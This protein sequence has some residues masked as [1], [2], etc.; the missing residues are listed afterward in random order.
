MLF[1]NP[2]YL[3]AFLGLLLPLAIHLWNRKQGKTIYVGSIRWL[4]ASENRRFNSLRLHEI[5]LWILRSLLIILLVLLLVDLSWENKTALSKFKTWILIEPNLLKDTKIREQVKDL[6]SKEDELHLLVK[7]FPLVHIADERFP[8]SRGELGWSYWSYLQE[9]NELPQAPQK[10]KLIVN[11]H[12]HHFSGKR[13]SLSFDVEW[14]V[15]P[16]KDKSFFL[17]DVIITNDS[18]HLLIGLN[19]ETGT[20]L[21]RFSTPKQSIIKSTDFPEIQFNGKEAFFTH[22]QQN[23]VSVRDLQARNG[24]IYYSEEFTTD[25]QYLK[26]ALESV[27]EY[28]HLNLKIKSELLKNQP[29]TFDKESNFIFWLSKQ[30]IQKNNAINPN[31]ILIALESN[32]VINFFQ[33][34]PAQ[35]NHFFLTQRLNPSLNSAVLS[36]DLPEEM[37]TALFSDPLV[38]R[39][40]RQFAQVPISQAQIQTKQREIS[41]KKNANMSETQHLRF[42]LWLI[43][44]I[45][46]ATERRLSFQKQG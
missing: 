13:P 41:S 27:N 19:D 42:P 14:I 24:I 39:R 45:L 22:H 38:N 23:K 44:V 15:L 25:F 35:K 5:P 46:F 37:L 32:T 10:V 31:Q 20:S 8:P 28:A 34:N 21:R 30:S 33:I 29:I 6:L 11:N 40:I 18:L 36:G 43:L 7:D 1:Q 16:Q 4:I 3:W 2:I 9:L 26:S 12:L 17:A